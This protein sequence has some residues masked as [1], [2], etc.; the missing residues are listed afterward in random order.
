MCSGLGLTLTLAWFLCIYQSPA[1]GCSPLKILLTLNRTLALDFHNMVFKFPSQGCL[2]KLYNHDQTTVA[3]IG[4]TYS[5]RSNQAFWRKKKSVINR[6]TVNSLN[7]LQA[8]STITMFT[9]I[10]SLCATSNLLVRH[11]WN[12]EVEKNEGFY[13]LVEWTG[14][15]YYFL[16]NA[17]LF[18]STMYETLKRRKWEVI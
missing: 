17:S 2:A 1:S 5:K 16:K 4:T 3:P 12:K 18:C 10:I 9:I 6:G 11:M 14:L 7:P 8:T 15:N 13:W